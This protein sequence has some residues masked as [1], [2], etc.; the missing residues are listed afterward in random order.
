MRDGNRVP[1]KVGVNGLEISELDEH[2]TPVD[3]L[4]P[5]SGSKKVWGQ[6]EEFDPDGAVQRSMPFR[7]RRSKIH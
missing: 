1:I 4:H 5:C 3:Q 7:T 6:T 2:D